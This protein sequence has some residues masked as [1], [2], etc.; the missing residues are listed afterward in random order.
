MAD[1][2]ILYRT[3][4]FTV[5]DYHAIVTDQSKS[6]DEKK[7]KLVDFIRGRFTERYITPLQQIP[8]DKK[9]G[10]CTMAIC[11]LMIEALESFWEG[12][13]D[14]RTTG[15]SSAAFTS[16]FKRSDNLKDFRAYAQLFYKNVRCGILHQAET[17]DGWKITRKGTF[18]FEPSTK[19][20]DATRFHE[21]MKQCLQTYCSELMRE[22]FDSPLWIAFKYK[23]EVIC[24]NC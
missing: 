6:E 1:D 13:R 15:A 16:F 18:L 17:T 10:F 2:T 14:T 21:E 22:Q 24:K 7:A 19:T 20:I 23:M 4:N 11:C 3:G 5:A 9:N 12:M 8:K